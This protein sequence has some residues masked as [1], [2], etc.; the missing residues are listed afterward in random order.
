[1]ALDFDQLFPGRFIKAGDFK[2]RDW[3]VTISKVRTEEME[4]RKGI[5]VKAIIGFVGKKR[6]WI[7]N[8]TNGMCLKAMFGRDAEK[9]IGKRVTLWPAPV[10]GY[11][12]G[13]RVRGSPDLTADLHFTLQ[14]PRKKDRPLVML[15]TPEPGARPAPAAAAQPAQPNPAPADVPNGVDDSGAPWAGDDSGEPDQDFA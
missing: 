1:M 4:G 13:I 11:D 5:E 3:T 9:W 8:K 14:L 6:E 7:V 2:G 15:K 12:M 10:E